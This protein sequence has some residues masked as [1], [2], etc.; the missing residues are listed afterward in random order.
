MGHTRPLFLY[1]RLFNTVVNI[2]FCW[3][4]D[5]NYGP[6]ELEATALPNGPQPLPNKD[7]LCPSIFQPFWLVGNLSFQSDCLKTSIDL[8]SNF[9]CNSTLYS[10]EHSDWLL[11]LFQPIRMLQNERS[12][13]L[14]WKSSFPRNGTRFWTTHW[15]FNVTDRT[16]NDIILC[17][18]FAE[19]IKYLLWFVLTRSQCHTN[20]RG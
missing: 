6:L 18:T 8:H 10:F 7:N 4:Q 1:F 5:S 3:W 11:K 15:Q 13:K 9:Q 19:E 16:I 14:R 17:S 20:F 2:I 12:V